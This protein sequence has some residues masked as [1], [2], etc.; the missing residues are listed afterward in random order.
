MDAEDFARRSRAEA[1]LFPRES[2]SDAVELA[3]MWKTVTNW[4]VSH[5]SALQEEYDVD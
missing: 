2:M 3:R 1:S 5:S 4:R